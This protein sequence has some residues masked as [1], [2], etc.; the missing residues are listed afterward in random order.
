MLRTFKTYK[1]YIG[2]L[3]LATFNLLPTAI[4]KKYPLF[5]LPF[6]VKRCAGDE[7]EQHCDVK[8]R[9][10][11]EEIAAIKYGVLSKHLFQRTQQNGGCSKPQGNNKFVSKTISSSYHMEQKTF[12]KVTSINGAHT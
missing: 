2:S 3:V 6:I 4:L 12:I 8:S 7:V 1:F 9:D 10:V 5:C 11:I